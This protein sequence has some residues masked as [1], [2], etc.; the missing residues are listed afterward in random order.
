M[1]YV[2]CIQNIDAGH[3]AQCKLL[4]FPFSLFKLKLLGVLNYLHVDTGEM[5]MHY[6]YPGWSLK[7]LTAANVTQS[8]AWLIDSVLLLWHPQ[9]TKILNG[10]EI[11]YSCWCTKHKLVTYWNEASGIK[12]TQGEISDVFVWIEDK[13]SLEEGASWE[14]PCSILAT[15]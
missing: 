5:A 3:I 9:S 4:S 14:I 12:N 6:C 15:L 1:F 10:Y 11:Q 13:H 2:T 8:T 7:H